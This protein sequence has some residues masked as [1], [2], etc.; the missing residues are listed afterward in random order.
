MPNKI[1]TNPY[2]PDTMVIRCQA[3]DIDMIMVS[4]D[5]DQVEISYRT[6]NY[7]E[8]TENNEMVFGTVVLD[9]EAFGRF[10]D[11]LNVLKAA[12]SGSY[13]DDPWNGDDGG[14]ND[15]H[16]FYNTKGIIDDS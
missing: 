12:I 14:T 4:R 9:A 11:H 6:I 3:S 13:D 16:P 2:R 8:K 5:G 15:P 10:V 1:Y 7:N